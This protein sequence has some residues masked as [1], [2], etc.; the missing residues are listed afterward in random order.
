MMAKSYYYKEA[1]CIEQAVDILEKY[2]FVDFN[3]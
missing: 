3:L 1:I 2:G